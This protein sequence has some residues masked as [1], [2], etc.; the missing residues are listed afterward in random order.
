MHAAKG[1]EFGMVVLSGMTSQPRRQTGVRVI[2]PPAG[3]YA[4]RLTK[5]VQTNDFEAALPVDEQ[6]DAG[7]RIRLLYVATT[8][9]RDHLVVSLH[10]TPRG[11]ETNATV[12]AERGGRR[13]RR[14]LARGNIV[15]PAACAGRGRSAAG[16][17]RLAGVDRRRP[18][19]DQASAHDQCVRV[20][21]LRTRGGAARNRCRR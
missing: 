5:D 17:G 10:R 13:R 19:R 21:G 9:A 3:G 4:V 6:M 1:L 12:L 2:W 15:R 14:Y 20:G 16:L 11:S 7:E 8:R 18:S